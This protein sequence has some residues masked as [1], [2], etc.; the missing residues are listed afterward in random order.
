[1]RSAQRIAIILLPVA[2]LAVGCKSGSSK[3]DQLLDQLANIA[4]PDLKVVRRFRVA[5]AV[6]GGSVTHRGRYVIEHDP[7]VNGDL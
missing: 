3:E 6:L 1:M 4:V 5:V 2:I 7:T